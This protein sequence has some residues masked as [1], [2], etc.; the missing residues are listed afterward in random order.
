MIGWSTHSWTFAGDAHFPPS[1]A[2]PEDAF[3]PYDDAIIDKHIQGFVRTNDAR[4]PYAGSHSHKHRGSV[5]F[6]RRDGND[7]KL[8]AIYRVNFDHPSGVAV[9]GDALFFAVGEELHWLAISAAGDNQKE[10][11]YTLPAYEGRALQRGGGGIGLAKLYD[12][13]TL[14]IVSAPGDG[15]NDV[16]RS[17]NEGARHTRFYRMVPDAFRPTSI[18]ILGEIKHTGMK[19]RP[20]SPVGYSENL[21]VITEC[22]TGRIYTVHT[23]GDWGMHGHGFWYLSRVDGEVGKPQLTRLQLWRQ[24]QDNSDCHHRSAA[25]VYA[26]RN[27]HLGFVCHERTVIKFNPTGRF[28]FKEGTR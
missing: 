1:N 15:W 26:D 5:F 21:S 20:D 25:T 28:D 11:S 19:R 3:Y 4:F 9:I 23:T 27:G 22:D 10:H 14:F 13:T 12:G 24:E 2:Q 17:K 6:V 8:H 7:L 18:Q 16:K